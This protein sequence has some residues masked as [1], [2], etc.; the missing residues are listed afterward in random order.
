MHKYF[1]WFNGLLL[2]CL[3]ASAATA[4]P[5]PQSESESENTTQSQIPDISE[6]ELHQKSAEFLLKQPSKQP[7]RIVQTPPTTETQISKPADIELDV[8][9]TPINVIEKRQI[10]PTGVIIIDQRE[11]KRYG[12]RT[13]GEVLRRQ[14][15]VVVGGPASFTKRYHHF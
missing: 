1:L 7:Q 6:V 13:I 10:S 14:A 15:G 12:H 5:V 11:I 2:T 3:F 8:I 9:G 4:T